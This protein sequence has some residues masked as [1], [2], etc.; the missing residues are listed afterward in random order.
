MK[1]KKLLLHLLHLDIILT[2]FADLQSIYRT[3][4]LLVLCFSFY[5]VYFKF[6]TCLLLVKFIKL[7]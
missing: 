4:K 3:I 6:S 2:I 7:F 1:I 5:V